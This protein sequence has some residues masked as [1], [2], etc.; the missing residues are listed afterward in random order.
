VP[1]TLKKSDLHKPTAAWYSEYLRSDRWKAFRKKIIAER[2][3]LCEVCKII[4]H[5]SLHHRT[6]IRLWQELPEDVL[7]VC[8]DC[9]DGIHK[10]NRLD[11]KP[12]PCISLIYEESIHKVKNTLKSIKHIANYTQDKQQKTKQTKSALR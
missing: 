6:Y 11:N 5:F 3:D 2:G 9:H 12:I 1:F 4:P 8:K 7:L 10:Q